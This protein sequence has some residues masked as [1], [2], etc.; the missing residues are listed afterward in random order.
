MSDRVRFSAFWM[1]LP[2]MVHHS[3]GLGLTLNASRSR[4]LRLSTQAAQSAWS[5]ERRSFRSDLSFRSICPGRL[6]FA[7]RVGFGFSRDLDRKELQRLTQVKLA[8]LGIG[9]ERVQPPDGLIG[10]ELRG[11]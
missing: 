7:R 3:P 6:S 1:W 11:R 2:D 9:V 5:F 10:A 4:K 8:V